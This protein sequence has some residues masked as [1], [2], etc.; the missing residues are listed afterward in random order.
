MH[1]CLALFSVLEYRGVAILWGLFTGSEYKPY[2]VVNK[3]WIYSSGGIIHYIYSEMVY[4]DGICVLY[5]YVYRASFCSHNKYG[6]M[7][8]D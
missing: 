3:D 5:I 6:S 1:A 7:T 8:I 4:A 2:F